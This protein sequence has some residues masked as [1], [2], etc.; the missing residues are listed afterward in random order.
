[1]KLFVI[2][3]GHLIMWPIFFIWPTPEVTHTFAALEV[4]QSI[5]IFYISLWRTEFKVF[6][7]SAL[8]RMIRSLKRVA[9]IE[10][11]DVE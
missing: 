3:G 11:I 5:L 4:L 6:V 1:M 9:L 2:M 10:Q 8:D 7:S